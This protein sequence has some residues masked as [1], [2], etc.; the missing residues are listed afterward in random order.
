MY[1]FEDIY[2][3]EDHFVPGVG[4]WL[5]FDTGA[6]YTIVG[7][8]S[9]DFIYIPLNEGWNLIG[10]WTNQ[11]IDINSSIHFSDPDNILVPGSMYEFDGTYNTTSIIEPGYGYWIRANVAGEIRLGNQ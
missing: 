6:E 11:P 10:S 5:R 7:T 1:G 3:P 8:L 9:S 4:Y 2:I